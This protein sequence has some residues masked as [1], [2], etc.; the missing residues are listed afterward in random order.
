MALVG[1]ALYI[2]FMVWSF[3]LYPAAASLAQQA[4]IPGFY[5]RS[6]ASLPSVAPT[7]TPMHSDIKG[8]IDHKNDVQCMSN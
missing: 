7:Q 1:H 5:G 8:L 3:C 6:S 2:V 4:R